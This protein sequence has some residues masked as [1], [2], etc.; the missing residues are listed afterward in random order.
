[1]NDGSAAARGVSLVCEIPAGMDVLNAQGP[2]DSIKN[3]ELVS[4]NP[5]LELAPGNSVTYR[6][7]IRG[8]VAGHQRL[9]AKLSSEGNPEPL[10]ED[11]ITRFYG[12]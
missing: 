1:K 9:R 11:E 5:V 2:V 8:N 6:V 3:R 10:T 12:E 4:F 7:H